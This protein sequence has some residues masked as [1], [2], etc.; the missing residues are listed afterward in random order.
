MSLVN[1]KF[2]KEILLHKQFSEAAFQP[3]ISLAT[4]YCVLSLYLEY[5][6]F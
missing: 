3:W 6:L 5:T 2:R 4:Q 1:Q